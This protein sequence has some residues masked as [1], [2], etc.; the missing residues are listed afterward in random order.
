MKGI[1]LVIALLMSAQLA[2]I[3]FI[4]VISGKLD[5]SL[6]TSNFS[7]IKWSWWANFAYVACSVGGLFFDA[8]VKTKINPVFQLISLIDVAQTI[9]LFVA[10]AQSK[11]EF[12][13]KKYVKNRQWLIIAVSL[14]TFAMNFLWDYFG[15]NLVEGASIHMLPS[16]LL[17][18]VCLALSAYFFETVAK[19]YRVS[20]RSI[21]WGFSIYA[22]AQ[23]LALLE[24]HTDNEKGI[25][26]IIGWS[27][28]L[29]SKSFICWGLLLIFKGEA[30]KS[31]RLEIIL[32]NLFHELKNLLYGIDGSAQKILHERN[33]KP[34]KEAEEILRN[35]EALYAIVQATDLLYKHEIDTYE[36]SQQKNIEFDQSTYKALIDKNKEEYSVN[37]LIEIAVRLTRNFTGSKVKFVKDYGGNCEIRCYKHEIIQILV[38]LFK[39]AYESFPNGV[40]EIMI[41]SRNKYLMKDE[42]GET[43]RKVVNVEISDK[44]PGIP[45]EIQEKVFEHGFSTKAATGRGQGLHIAKSFIES[46]YGR[47]T[48]TSPYFHNNKLENGAKFTIYFEIL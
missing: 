19:S 13:W 48:L 1:E 29:I 39:N 27:L 37:T 3:L 11:Y 41:K 24:A 33:V 9:I 21:K 32:S 23:F 30:S 20:S 4:I 15:W 45:H 43:E 2:V 18:F 36:I 47:L 22:F 6:R 7:L 28:G 25:I 35:Y 40:G 8:E 17:N 16:I 31:R 44:G 42:D 38:N 46:K 5:S 26:S 12:R 34:K 14:A 10:I